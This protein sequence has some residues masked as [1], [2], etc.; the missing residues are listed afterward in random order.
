MKTKPIK[1]N[2]I[3]QELDKYKEN[4][5]NLIK[6]SKYKEDIN[7]YWSFFGHYTIVLMIEK[8]RDRALDQIREIDFVKYD[9]IYNKTKIFYTE[10]YKFYMEIGEQYEK[11]IW[12]EYN[13]LPSKP[14]KPKPEIIVPKSKKWYEFWK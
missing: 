9:K 10:K 3:Q 4:S 5:L 6:R 8:Q 1:D 2:Y 14:T 7:V 12:Y 11:E 13:K